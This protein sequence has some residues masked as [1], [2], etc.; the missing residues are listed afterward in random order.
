MSEINDVYSVVLSSGIRYLKIETKKGNFVGL[1]SEYNKNIFD[2]K[3]YIISELDNFNEHEILDVID[4]VSE[5]ALKRSSKKVG[6][7]DNG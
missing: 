3:K 4:F 1:L 2:Y 7:G 6:G 5:I